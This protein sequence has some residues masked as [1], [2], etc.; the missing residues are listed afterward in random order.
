MRLD[1]D[2]YDSTRDALEALYPRLSPGGFVIVDDYGLPTGCARAVDE[3][4]EQHGIDAPLEWANQQAVYW[5]K[6]S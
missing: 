6:P 5:R 2:W 3:Y 4:R 1:G